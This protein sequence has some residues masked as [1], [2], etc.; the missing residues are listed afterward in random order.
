MEEQI[1]LTSV[2]EPALKEGCYK[3]E[4]IEKTNVADGITFKDEANIV[5]TSRRYRLQPDEVYS[6]YP[7]KD[8]S[9]E[10]EGC[11]PHIVFNRDTIPWEREMFQGDRDKS[12]P[13]MMLLLLAE[14]EDFQ[15][16]EMTIKEALEGAKNPSLY[17]GREPGALEE[18]MEQETDACAVVDISAELAACVLP[19]WEEVKLLAHGRLVSLE[20]KVTD[21]TVK[22]GWFSCLVSNRYVKEEESRRYHACLISLKGFEELLSA[23]GSK[24]RISKMAG[25]L[26]VRFFVLYEWAFNS[27]LSPYSFTG[28]IRQLRAGTLCAKV[29][30]IVKS[31]ELRELLE[32]GYFPVNHR[33]RDGSRTVSWYRG[34]LLPQHEKREGFCYHV[35]SD[36]LSKYDPDMGMMDMSYSGAWQLGRM[37]AFQNQSYCKSLIQWRFENCRRAA[38]R[39]QEE[40]IKAYISRNTSPIGAGTIGK[41]KSPMQG[42]SNTVQEKEEQLEDILAEQCMKI[43]SEHQFGS[44]EENAAP[45]G[46]CIESG[47]I[48]EEYFQYIQ[49]EA[50]GQFPQP[51]KDFIMECSLLYHVP[52]WYLAPDADMLKE[53]ELRFFCIDSDWIMHMMDGMCSIARNASI[54]YLHDTELLN[55]LFMQ[56]MECNGAIRR[57]KQGIEENEFNTKASS[58]EQVSENA[59]KKQKYTGFLLRSVLVKDFRGLEFQ[60]YDAREGGSRLEP[61]RLDTLGESVLL[62]IFRGDVKRLVIGQPPE[63]LH[64]GFDWVKTQQV[65]KGIK[66]LRGLKDGVLNEKETYVLLREEGK[67]QCIDAVKTKDAISKELGAD[68]DSAGFALEMIKNAHSGVFQID[69]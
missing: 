56:V 57:K 11:M 61:L 41:S 24:E 38:E 59:D 50:E 20:N 18:G 17:M 52:F 65:N 28:L 36:Q 5:V 42:N 32:R 33:L 15:K 6:V 47:T 19:E 40:E 13:W 22:S 53:E 55:S 62:G 29:K 37:L 44:N 27:T 14:G 3:V 51:V 7:P 68:I 2:C 16:H 43:M 23:K 46:A 10:Y 8:S 60:A 12:C 67:Y 1:R 63:G 45:P 39:K 58:K 48:K 31:Q 9:G 49:K 34:P 54:D 4:V 30:D 25:A 66:Y 69:G 64:F 35:F 26:A 21:S